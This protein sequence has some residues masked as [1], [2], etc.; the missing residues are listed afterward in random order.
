MKSLL[1]GLAIIIPLGL[2]VRFAPILLVIPAFLLAMW[3]LGEMVRGIL[4]KGD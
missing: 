2:I 3:M 1:V 4:F